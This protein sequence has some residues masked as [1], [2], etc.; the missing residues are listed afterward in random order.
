MLK[1]YA[2]PVIY[3][4]LIFLISAMVIFGASINIGFENLHEI[5]FY[6]GSNICHQLTYR[7]FVICGKQ[8]FLCSRCAG[9]FFGIFVGWLS[10][11]LSRSKKFNYLDKSVIISMVLPMTIDAATQYLGIRES[12]NLIRFTTGVFVGGLIFFCQFCILCGMLECSFKFKVIPRSILKIFLLLSAAICVLFGYVAPSLDICFFYYAE[13]YVMMISFVYNVIALCS[14][15][16]LLFYYHIY[17]RYRSK[18]K[19]FKLT[20]KLIKVRIAGGK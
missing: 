12:N 19:S 16:I 14:L 2:N 18:R 4:L 10:V 1:I 11:T 7:S 6:I 13:E 9:A 17:M 3:P 15:L 5:F 20:K 8:V